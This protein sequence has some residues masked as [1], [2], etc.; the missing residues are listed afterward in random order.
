MMCCSRSTLGV[1]IG[2]I[3]AVAYFATLIFLIYTM[4]DTNSLL[5]K[6]E[7]TKTDATYFNVIFTL[8]ILFCMSMFV[9]SGLLLMGIIKRRHKM[10]I[11]W[12]LLSA[13]GFVINTFR[14]SYQLI[15][16]IINDVGAGIFVSIFFSG[17]LGLG[18]SALIIW[19]IYTLYKD[20]EKENI[21]KPTQI[22][23]QTSA[24]G[25]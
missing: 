5:K 25:Y 8:L 10:M 23:Y 15:V 12:L 20:I 6:H 4:V 2:G 3:N 16:S 13:I 11:P 9:I 7:H 24:H 19:L 14:L 18:L 21:L 1:I 17:L 22:N